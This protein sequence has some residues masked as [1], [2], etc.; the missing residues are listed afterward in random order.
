VGRACGVFGGVVDGVVGAEHGQRSGTAESGAAAGV[1]TV[2]ALPV[3]VLACAFS[4]RFFIGCY[5]IGGGAAIACQSWTVQ[6]E[7]AADDPRAGFERW[8]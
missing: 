6:P 8:S 2:A 7:L 3:G 5:V 4:W 1:L